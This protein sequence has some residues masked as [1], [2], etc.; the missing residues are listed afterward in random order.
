MRNH[1]FFSIPTMRKPLNKCR[2]KASKA[3]VGLRISSTNIDSA[4]YCVINVKRKKNVFFHREKT[5]RCCVGFS[6]ELLT[7]RCA[8]IFGRDVFIVG[9]HFPA[10][11]NYRTVTDAECNIWLGF[12]CRH[13]PVRPRPM[14]RI[15]RQSFCPSKVILNPIAT[16]W[17]DFSSW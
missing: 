2:R 10:A 4:Y 16:I 11:C 7:W 13:P 8:A 15:K 3:K 12:P 17:L 9:Y 1:F 6:C 14:W 5:R